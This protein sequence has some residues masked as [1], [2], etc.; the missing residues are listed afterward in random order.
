[1]SEPI[2]HLITHLEALARAT[3]AG[4]DPNAAADGG[5]TLL[6]TGR[7]HVMVPDRLLGQVETRQLDPDAAIAWQMIR[8]ALT[9]AT[10]TFHRLYAFVREQIHCSRPKAGDVV[11]LLRITRWLT[12]RDVRTPRGH[13]LPLIALLHEAPLRLEE[14]LLIDPQFPS[15]VRRCRDHRHGMIQAA[16]GELEAQLAERAGAVAG[17]EM[18][19]PKP[20]VKKF[21]FGL[22]QNQDFLLWDEPKSKKIDLG[23]QKEDQ[24]VT[25]KVKKIDFGSADSCCCC[26]NTNTTTTTD[27]ERI[28]LP[29]HPRVKPLIPAA[30]AAL[31][32]TSL[33]H[34]LLQEVAHEWAGALI[35]P[36]AKVQKPIPYLRS[37]LR[38]AERGAFCITDLGLGQRNAAASASQ[39]AKP[40]GS[41]IF[42]PEKPS[43]PAEWAP[44]LEAARREL[45]EREFATWLAPL[46]AVERGERVQLYAPNAIVAERVRADYLPR[47]ERFFAAHGRRV[48]LSA[49][50]FR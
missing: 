39:P 34:A 8:R 33:P 28:D 26:I 7:S 46:R 10:P 47:I 36:G 12:L 25:A 43:P 22:A 14:T 38:A 11:A 24:E 37:L 17:G 1:M 49:E 40:G 45:P 48:D 35:A 27:G 9:G 30:R 13:R 3:A 5:A 18:A 2:E 23:K 44:F 20:K 50:V 42:P 29:A 31:A 15:F 4:V 21:D 6:F 41:N 16:A 32:G 19:A